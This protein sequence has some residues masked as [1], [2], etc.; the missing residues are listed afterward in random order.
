[1]SLERYETSFFMA[2]YEN[3]FFTTHRKKMLPFFADFASIFRFS[4]VP[5]CVLSVSNNE[6]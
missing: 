4:N 1:M 5:E 6:K 3:N 2:K